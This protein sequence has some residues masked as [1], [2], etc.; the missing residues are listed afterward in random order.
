MNNKHD[1]IKKLLKA[2]R[3]MLTGERLT[4]DIQQIRSQ[5]KLITEQGVD[6]TDDNITKKYDVAQSVE[7]KIEDD[8]ESQSDKKQAY[9]ISG[10]ILVLHGKDKTDIDLTTDDKTAF[11]ETMDE[12]VEEVSDLVDFNK[13]NVYPNNVEWSGKLIEFDLEFFFSIG[14]EN[15]TYIN[16]EMIK[17]DDEFLELINKLKAYY[18]KFKSKWSK[19]LASRKKTSDDE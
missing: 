6:L 18:E 10:G 19:I 9:R 12:F 17:T 3:T 16:G 2:S 15:G 8:V 13:L 11:Q 14:E 7:D 4:E 1:E 5:Y